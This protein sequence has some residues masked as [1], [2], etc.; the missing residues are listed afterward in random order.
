MGNRNRWQSGWAGIALF[1]TLVSLVSAPVILEG[2]LYSRQQTAGSSSPENTAALG[3]VNFTCTLAYYESSF[4]IS[5]SI[6]LTDGMNMNEALLVADVLFNKTMNA[7][8]QSGSAE[9]D[10][11]GLWKVL[12]IW[13]YSTLDLGHWFRAEID[14]FNRTIVYSHCK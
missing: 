3:L 10:E 5:V 4:E 1:T 13:G 2:Y 11:L 9:T 8:H 6:N 7:L 12:I 14:P